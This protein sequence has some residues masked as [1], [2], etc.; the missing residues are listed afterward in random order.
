MSEEQVEKTQPSKK[1]VPSTTDTVNAAQGPEDSNPLRD[2]L[3]T[4]R[5]VRPERSEKQ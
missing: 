2:I 4:K 1:S 5:D 3:R